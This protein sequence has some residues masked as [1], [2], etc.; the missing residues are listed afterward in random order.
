MCQW[1][2]HLSF[3][4]GRVADHITRGMTRNNAVF[5]GAKVGEVQDLNN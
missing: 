4:P 1:H 3:S 2:M 5:G